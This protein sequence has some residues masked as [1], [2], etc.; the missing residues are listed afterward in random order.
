MS[1]ESK[2]KSGHSGDIRVG[3]ITNAK[4]IAVGHE[5]SANVTEGIS[6]EDI[7]K[8][9]QPILQKAADLPEG[10]SKAIAQQAVTGLQQE[11]QKGDAAQE[12][13]VSTWFSSLAQFAPDV[14]DVA[15]TTLANPVAG[16]AKVIQLVAK[17]AKEEKEARQ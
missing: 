3:D 7:A 16:V 5:A 10:P 11:V 6:G 15:V 4:G 2:P 12:Q 9:F 17:K 14:W 8:V 13:N 1:D